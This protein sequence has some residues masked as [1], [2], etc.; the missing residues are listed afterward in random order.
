MYHHPSLTSYH[1]IPNPP[2]PIPPHP[3]PTP[4]HTTPSQTHSIPNTTSPNPTP[5]HNTPNYTMLHHNK[6]I[7]H[8]PHTPHITLPHTTPDTPL[9]PIPTPISHHPTS[10]TPPH[11]HPSTLYPTPPHTNPDYPTP[12]TPPRPTPHPPHNNILITIQVSLRIEDIND[13]KPH[14]QRDNIVL[15]LPKDASPG[16]SFDL[17]PAIDLDTKDTLTYDLVNF[18]N[19]F[20][21]R[22]DDPSKKVSGCG[23]SGEMGF[24]GILEGVTYIVH[25][26]IYTV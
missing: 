12:P 20:S 13:N 17:D 15:R 3:I 2:H 6:N 7:P 16:Y 4:S 19:T 1:P 23:W 9:N 5:N 26:Y 10:S 21:L 18:K 11:T 8:P 14:F 22:Y 25:Y 24:M